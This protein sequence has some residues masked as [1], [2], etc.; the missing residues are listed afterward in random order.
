MRRKRRRKRERIKV[1]RQRK[2]KRE[3]GRE[4]EYSDRRRGRKRT[5][6]KGFS[7]NCLYT[8]PLAS[9]ITLTISPFTL[10]MSLTHTLLSSSSRI[11]WCEGEW[12]SNRMDGCRAYG[13][14]VLI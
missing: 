5:K 12:S 8:S 14:P 3:R 13:N 9:C 7:V 4:N 2:R 1:Q 6:T 10:Q 11:H